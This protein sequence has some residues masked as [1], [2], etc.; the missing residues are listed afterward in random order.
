LANRVFF[1]NLK[2]FTLVPDS[3]PSPELRL[4][5]DFD[6]LIAAKDLL[7]CQWILE[8]RGYRISAKTSSTWEFKAGDHASAKLSNPYQKTPFRSVELHFTPNAENTH[9]DISDE[10]LNQLSLWHYEGHSFPALT[11]PDQFV[12]QATHILAHLRSATT[13]PQWLLEFGRHA[14]A[15]SKDLRFWRDVQQLARSNPLVSIALGISARITRDTFG[16]AMHLPVLDCAEQSLPENVR[17]WVER[18]GPRVVMADFPGTKLYL[19]LERELALCSVY[20][21]STASSSALPSLRIPRLFYPQPAQTIRARLRRWSAQSR[22]FLFRLRFHVV[23]G[24][25]YHFE[26]RRWKTRRAPR[27]HQFAASPQHADKLTK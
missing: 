8:E 16:L 19:L 11:A 5:L 6:F 1:A 18:Y 4:Q 20:Q 14:A 10:R 9:P 24:L 17:L 2:G 26:A 27:L 15:R 22:Y 23:E 25:R 13:R 7:K 21:R 3:C 12:G